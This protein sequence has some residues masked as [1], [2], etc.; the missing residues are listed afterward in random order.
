M[1]NTFSDD[2]DRFVNW[3]SR[4]AFEL[5]F[6]EKAITIAQQGKE[7]LKILD[8]ACGTGMHAISLSRHGYSVSGADLFPNMIDRARQNARE[9]NADVRFEVAGFGGL[10]QT[11]GKASIDAL[12]CL[13]NSLPHVDNEAALQAA[14]NDFAMVLRPGGVLLLQNRNFD[15]VMAQKIRWMEPQAHREGEREWAFFRFYD[16]EPDG[17]IQFHI[18]TLYR[19]G[20]RNWQQTLRS[21]RLFPLLQVDLNRA[22]IATGFS[23]M[24]CFGSMDGSTFSPEQ[25]ENLII[26]AR[27]GHS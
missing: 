3:E 20:A 14:L 10:T 1:Y 9:A 22:L 27:N 15:K 8:V 18:V 13:G 12:V 16:F 23:D 5:P 24:Q 19:E 17:H 26:T 11:F 7:A 2:Y 21:T 25:S 4:L 6:I